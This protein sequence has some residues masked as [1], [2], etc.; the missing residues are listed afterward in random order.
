[1]LH[2]KASQVNFDPKVTDRKS[3]LTRDPTPFPKELHSKAMQWRAAREKGGP[4]HGRDGGSPSVGMDEVALRK[5]MNRR[6]PNRYS[7]LKALSDPLIEVIITCTCTNVHTTH[8]IL[9]QSLVFKTR[10]YRHLSSWIC[11]SEDSFNPKSLLDT[12]VALLITHI[13]ASRYAQAGRDMIV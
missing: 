9:V 1:M 13:F 2:R 10:H 7:L 12:S 6:L 3:N 8:I 5:P 4:H 11:L